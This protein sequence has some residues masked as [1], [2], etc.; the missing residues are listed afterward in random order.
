MQALVSNHMWL[1][2]DWRKLLIPEQS[3]LDVI[4]RGSIVYLMLFLCIRFL[5]RRRSGGIGLPDILVVVL[6]A[7]A[8]QNAMGSDYKSVTEGAVLVFT[9]LFWDY[10]LDWVGHRI[11]WLRRFT[12]PAPL[13]LIKDGRL[14]RAN[15]RQEMVTTEELLSQL[16][17]QG[18]DDPAEVKMACLEGDGEI[19]VVKRD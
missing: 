18:I 17:Q 19:S 5:L 3:I 12:R 14:Q 15:M 9:I 7:D 16:R 11:P 10:A 8:V 4:I 1:Q 6:L 13:L 2:I